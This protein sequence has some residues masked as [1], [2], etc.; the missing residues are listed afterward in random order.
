MNSID[1]L[2]RFAK[3]PA[4][5]K[6]N[7]VQRRLRLAP[8]TIQG[9]LRAASSPAFWRAKY[10]F[11]RASLPNGHR[12]L[13]HGL[14]PG[15]D[16]M[17]TAIFK[18]LSI[19]RCD[20]PVAMVSNFP[21]LF[22]GLL[23]STLIL[24]AGDTYSFRDRPLSVYRR[25]SGMAGGELVQLFFSRWLQG[26]Q[27]AAP[28]RHYIAELCASAGIE[29]PISIRPY[30]SL[31]ADEISAAAWASGRIIIQSS[32]AGAR[33]HMRLKDWFPERYQ[34]LVDTLRKE[35]EFVQIGS[36]KDPPLEHVLDLRGCTT[37]REAAAILDNARLNIGYVGFLMHLARAVDCPSVIVYGGREA[38][39]QSG[40]ICNLNLYNAVPCAPCWRKNLCDFDHRCMREI[41]AGDVVSAIQ[42]MLN[43][44]RGPLAVETV[45]I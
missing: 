11:S 12:L 17:C 26:D 5:E 43:R 37:M 44:P 8:A 13:F 19:R 28:S 20:K 15:D 35:W 1:I 25:L 42:E 18:E 32:G 27:N 6:L 21:E 4:R 16:L 3:K 22:P 31:T 2:T 23:N 9:R 41:S 45:S 38:P 7:A 10:H 33:N 30:I 24:P 39:W 14:T 29:G 40:Y 36:R 34:E